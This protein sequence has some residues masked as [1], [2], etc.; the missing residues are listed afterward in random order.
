MN[1]MKTFI[2]FSLHLLFQ[3]VEKMFTPS[4]ALL[5]NFGPG[6]HEHGIVSKAVDAVIATRF[7]IGKVGVGA[8]GSTVAVCGL[9]DTPKY[10]LRDAAT[11]IGDYVEARILGLGAG[12]DKMVAGAIVTFGQRLV[13][14]AGGLVK[15]LPAAGGIY[16]VVGI[17]ESAAA[18]GDDF[19]VTPVLP[20]QVTVTS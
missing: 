13:P 8:S 6:V 19:E 14:M 3:R 18:I 10:L 12:T 5:A 1:Q 15:P 9:S 4:G 16:W 11:A 17:A 7:L 20:Y 2:L